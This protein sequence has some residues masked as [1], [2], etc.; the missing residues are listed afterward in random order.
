MPNTVKFNILDFDFSGEAYS[1]IENKM[2]QMIVIYSDDK[3]LPYM[4][5]RDS[6]ENQVGCV[7]IRK[8]TK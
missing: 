2:Y 4:W 6:N 1:K 5:D 3:D 7:F 8:G